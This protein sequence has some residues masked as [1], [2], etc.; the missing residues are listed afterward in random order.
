MEPAL[1]K[2]AEEEADPPLVNPMVTAV[3]TA[4]APV[5]VRAY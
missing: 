4:E 2:E 5:A 1:L 3:K